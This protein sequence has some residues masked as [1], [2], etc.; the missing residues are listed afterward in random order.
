[1]IQKTSYK[2]TLTASNGQKIGIRFIHLPNLTGK[3]W[4]DYVHRAITKE[5]DVSNIA[6]WLRGACKQFRDSMHNKGGKHKLRIIPLL[7]QICQHILSMVSWTVFEVI[8][9]S[10]QASRWTDSCW[11][12][13]SLPHHSD[14]FRIICL[15]LM[16]YPLY[17]FVIHGKEPHLYCWVREVWDECWDHDNQCHNPEGGWWS[18]SFNE[19]FV[20]ISRNAGRHCTICQEEKVPE[21]NGTPDE[22]VLNQGEVIYSNSH[23]QV[24]NPNHT[25]VHCCSEYVP[26]SS[27]SLLIKGLNFHCFCAEKENYYG[28]Y[29]AI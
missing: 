13:W 10:H 14:E 11:P 15:S 5:V 18:K 9:L 29:K 3:W 1:M 17:H 21:S 6:F 27:S 12:Q 8:I 23:L 4:F 28:T 24:H 20:S 19:D 16:P 22:N 25:S 2:L 26:A 7:K